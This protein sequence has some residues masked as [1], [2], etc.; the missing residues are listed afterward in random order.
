MGP[1]TCSILPSTSNGKAFAHLDDSQRLG[2]CFSFCCNLI[3]LLG[4]QSKCGESGIMFPLSSF[5]VEKN[6][7]STTPDEH[8]RK[9]MISNPE[10]TMPVVSLVV[11]NNYIFHPCFDTP[12]RKQIVATKCRHM[13]TYIVQRNCGVLPYFLWIPNSITVDSICVTS[14]IGRCKMKSTFTSPHCNRH[15]RTITGEPL[16][17]CAGKVNVLPKCCAPSNDK[18][19][20]WITGLGS[21][22]QTLLGLIRSDNAQL[23]R[24]N[25]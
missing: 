23:V 15:A 11:V 17:R 10:V 16:T 24:P 9:Q 2:T 19:G 1:D 3:Q 6:A 22:L 20:Q 18:Q 21:T 8:L 25:Q 5:G 12:H 13:R 14:A 7:S 4:R